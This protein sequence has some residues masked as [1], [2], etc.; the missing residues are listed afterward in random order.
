MAAVE[1][2]RAAAAEE[3]P[4]GTVGAHLTAD[5]EGDRVVTHLFEC[6]EPGYRGWRWAVT[7]ARASRARTVT[8]DEVVLL[9]GPDSLLAPAWLPWSERLR[10]GD[11]G[12]GDVLPTAPDDPR[13]VAGL[14]GEDDLEGLSSPSPLQPGQWEI[15]LGRERVLSELGRLEAADRWLAGDHGPE[16]AMAK[17]A[18][19]RCATCGFLLV[20]GGPLGQ[21][22]GLC[23]NE[24]SPSDGHVV[25]LAHGCGGHSS[26][27]VDSASAGNGEPVRDEVGYDVLDLGHS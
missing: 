25:A 4:S 2:A 27:D 15:G 14:T 7:V 10:P 21:A 13:L 20:I 8:V 23:A 11:L 9:P 24:I 19:G 6:L 3:A 5:A 16:S 1:Q 26:V 18:P 12:P 22:F 17:A